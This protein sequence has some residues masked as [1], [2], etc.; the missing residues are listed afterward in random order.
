MKAVSKAKASIA[1]MKNW[2]WA[3]REKEGPF[4]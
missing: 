3:A 1:E 4:V 2:D